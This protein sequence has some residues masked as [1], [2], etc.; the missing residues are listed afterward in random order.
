MNA[1]RWLAVMLMMSCEGVIEGTRALV[2][3]VPADPQPPIVIE[4]EPRLPARQP[5]AS[6][7]RRLT[8]AELA[9]AL[10]DVLGASSPEIFTALPPDLG[11]YENDATNQ[12]PSAIFVEGWEGISR[13]VAKDTVANRRSRLLTCTARGPGDDRCLAEAVRTVGRLLFRRPLSDD[14]VAEF[15]TLRA[16]GLLTE[17]FDAALEAV[18]SAML[19]DPRFLYRVELGRPGAPTRLSSHELATRLSFFFW[20]RTPPAWLLDLADE[21][22][23]ERADQVEAIARRLAADPLAAKQ[24]E[25]FHAQWLGYSSLP[26][27]PALSSA[28]RA[29]TNAAVSRFT[30]EGQDYLELFRTTESYLDDTLAA[31]YGLSLPSAAGPRWIAYGT[32]QRRGILSHGALLA[33]GAKQGDTS[34]TLRGKWVRQKL[35]CQTVPP[36]PPNSNVDAQPGEVPSSRCKKDRYSAHA[37][38]GACAGCHKAM[39]PIGFGLENYDREGRW[40]AVEA[41]APEC[42]IDGQGDVDGTNR[43][44]GAPGL[45]QLLIETGALEGCVVKQLTQFAMGRPL[46]ADDDRFVEERT[47]DFRRGGH[48][49]LELMI[50]IATSDDFRARRP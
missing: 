25:A 5:L 19:Q 29:E 50:A 3:E 47:A 31:H 40:R 46:I 1:R 2:T 39:D 37:R 30:G 33:N 11:A 17:R 15:V 21:D 42:V 45:A 34:P 48:R 16:V 20:A 43:F 6:E 10:Q 32:P 27:A 44:T 13:A 23:L 28:M 9:W 36:P 49:F 26:F 12:R 35:M 4:P 7:L 38:V 14:E 8:R 41:E 22:G 24:I 18:V